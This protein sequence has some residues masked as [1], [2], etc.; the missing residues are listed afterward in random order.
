MASEGMAQFW[1]LFVFGDLESRVLV[2]DAVACLVRPFA[3]SHH[4][5]DVQ[6]DQLIWANVLV[7][8][9]AEMVVLVLGQGGTDYT[10]KGVL[11]KAVW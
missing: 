2:E 7:D 5:A 9:V 10:P 6:P 3:F 4:V 11:S 1:E 8:V